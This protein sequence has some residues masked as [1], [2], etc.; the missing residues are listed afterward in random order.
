MRASGVLRLLLGAR[1]LSRVRPT[2]RARTGSDAAGRTTRQPVSRGEHGIAA[3][4]SRTSRN[5]TGRRV[6]L[7]LLRAQRRDGEPRDQRHRTRCSSPFTSCAPA[8]T[9]R[10]RAGRAMPCSWRSISPPLHRAGDRRDRRDRQAPLGRRRGRAP[11]RASRRARPQ[12]PS[13]H[14][15]EIDAEARYEASLRRALGDRFD[16]LYAQ[17]LALDERGMITLAFTQLDAIIQTHDRREGPP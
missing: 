8:T 15:D 2:R 1:P 17:G 7:P 6:L 14:R 3:A 5:P 11:R 13:R 4:I 16:A 10:R 12:A 9:S